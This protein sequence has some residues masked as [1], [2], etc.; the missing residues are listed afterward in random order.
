[1]ILSHFAM[2]FIEEN[3]S[4]PDTVALKSPMIGIFKE[5]CVWKFFIYVQISDQTIGVCTVT[6]AFKGR[7]LFKHDL[8]DVV[9][10]VAKVGRLWELYPGFRKTISLTVETSSNLRGKHDHQIKKKFYQQLSVLFN[11]KDHWKSL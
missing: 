5:W 2:P 6:G 8:V 11:Y 7:V 9:L 1:M 10:H 4:I 3:I